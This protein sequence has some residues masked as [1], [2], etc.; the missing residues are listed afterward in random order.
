MVLAG[1]LLFYWGSDMVEDQS[2]TI[3]GQTVE[4]AALHIGYTAEEIR[5]LA[6]TVY[7]NVSVQEILRADDRTEYESVQDFQILDQIIMRVE[8][9]PR[10]YRARLFV[11][12]DKFYA[13]DRD[14]IFPYGDL[15]IPLP[16]TP[17]WTFSS[18]TPRI[19]GSVTPRRTVAYLMPVRDSADISSI[20]GC[21]VI[22]VLEQ[23]LIDILERIRPDEGWTYLVDMDGSPFAVTGSDLNQIPLFSRRDHS[24][25]DIDVT[26]FFRVEQRIEE[27]P[28]TLV[29]VIPR[30]ELLEG[31]VHM[32]RI[33]IVIVAVIAILA[34]VS[35]VMVAGRITKGIHELTERMRS[36]RDLY[37]SE[38]RTEPVYGKDE[39]GMLNENF[40]GMVQRFR[41]LVRE[42]YI[43]RIEQR[44]AE[45]KALQAQI[46][47]HFLYNVL[48]AINWQAVRAGE[49]R[50][51]RMVT[52]LGRFYRMGLSGGKE[53]VT[54][55]EELEYVRTYLEIQRIRFGETLQVVFDIPDDIQRYAIAKLTLQPLV[56]NAIMHGIMTKPDQDGCIRI[57]GRGND[58]IIRLRIE[59]DGADVD[60]DRIRY[61]LVPE[62]QIS[63]DDENNRSGSGFGI[64]NVDERIKLYF[65]D[66]YGLSVRRQAG[67]WT[68]AEISLPA[69]EI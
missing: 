65:G 61:L 67:K 63:G 24:M 7:T 62:E 11:S 22:D 17:L 41:Q 3:I 44:E 15:P 45:F 59:D 43:A 13:R 28:W 68:V 53:I 58:G 51:S 2:L 30:D 46:N 47:P 23:D 54:I 9:T 56:E 14:S 38:E 36:I 8:D 29:H 55:G 69:T 6:E 31:T 37:E 33:I 21:L 20:L 5:F 39:I 16:Q 49:R 60:F 19:F 1:M 42:N 4:Q 18:A 10:V 48:E 26:R 66:Q 40:D 12:N 27:F 35:A 57:L 32:A 52:L 34:T 64:R 25:D 50:I